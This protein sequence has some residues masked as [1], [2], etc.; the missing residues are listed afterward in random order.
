MTQY[1][2]KSQKEGVLRI[3]G[4]TVLVIRGTLGLNI[5]S[6]GSMCSRKTHC[7]L[8]RITAEKIRWK[9]VSVSLCLIPVGR[10]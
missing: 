6:F 3:R 9:R 2:S 1:V 10:D 5:G 4:N 8:G 7:G